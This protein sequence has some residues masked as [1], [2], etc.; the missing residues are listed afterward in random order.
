[1]V[2]ATRRLPKVSP[3]R[4]EIWVKDIMW[5]F[6]KLIERPS[7]KHWSQC[8]LD[9]IEQFGQPPPQML[10]RYQ[11]DP[12]ATIPPMTVLQEELT[13]KALEHYTTQIEEF[14]SFFDNFGEEQPF[15][16]MPMPKIKLRE[17]VPKP[18]SEYDEW[19]SW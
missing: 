18:E 15:K 14:C 10:S 6:P 9:I 13:E 19:G 8:V 11:D 7:R 4:L 3:D 17:K 16:I 2:G 1:M 12:D 5:R